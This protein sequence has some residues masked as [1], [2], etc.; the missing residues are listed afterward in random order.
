MVQLQ[1]LKDQV[2]G[3][4]REAWVLDSPKAAMDA[5]NE[6]M[7]LFTTL[8]KEVQEEEAKRKEEEE[9]KKSQRRVHPAAIKNLELLRSIPPI[10]L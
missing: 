8:E 6:V 4:I 7:E 5:E 2:I 9:R 10:R 1:K 3:R